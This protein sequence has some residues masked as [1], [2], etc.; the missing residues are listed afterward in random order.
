[1][2]YVKGDGEPSG[3]AKGREV[4][5]PLVCGS[6]EAVWGCSAAESEG[7][8]GGCGSVQVSGNSLT[9]CCVRGVEGEGLGSVRG[10]KGEAWQGGGEET[11]VP[12]WTSLRWEVEEE[13]PVWVGVYPQPVG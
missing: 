9:H 3:E 1:M 4:A 6:S 8:L 13:G 7:Q 10:Q 11:R 12:G 2:V 5:R